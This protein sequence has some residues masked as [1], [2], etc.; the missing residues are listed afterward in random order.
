[1]PPA[2]EARLATFRCYSA[3]LPTACS[4]KQLC[5]F[6]FCAVLSETQILP[7]ATARM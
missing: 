2:Y 6:C 7:E 5:Y 1:M 3:N 4:V